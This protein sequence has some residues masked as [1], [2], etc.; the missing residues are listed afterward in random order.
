[1][2]IRKKIVYQKGIDQKIMHKLYCIIMIFLG[3]FNCLPVSYFIHDAQYYLKH[4]ANFS[5]ITDEFDNFDVNSNH[6]C[7]TKI[8][9][10]FSYSITNDK[11]LISKA[12]E[13]KFNRDIFIIA[14][15]E[16]ISEEPVKVFSNRNGKVGLMKVSGEIIIK[17][18]YESILPFSENLAIIKFNKK[19]GA[20]DKNGTIVIPPQ[21]EDMESFENGLARVR[22]NGKWGI[23]NKTGN[24][25]IPIEYIEIGNFSEGLAFA[26][27]DGYLFG[28]IDMSNNFIIPPVFK[29]A[30]AFR[31]GIAPASNLNRE[32]GY[33]NKSGYYIIS[34]KYSS[35]FSF[36]SGLAI[37]YVKRGFGVIDE[38]GKLV[39]PAQFS[40]LTIDE[41]FKIIKATH[42]KDWGN[43]LVFDL[44]NCWVVK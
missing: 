34:P 11:I 43:D 1:M 36:Q 39:F 9:K 15:E 35:A 17:P 41:K 44:H 8:R 37:V 4:D 30:G 31:N 10:L 21:Y 16:N 19:W 7:R 18:L 40:H 2:Q 33:I 42:Y 23:I 14:K 12:N 5:L 38:I 28:Y 6:P 24:N 3:I 20:V 25:V 13:Y 22:L 32:Y 27:K 29:N 26:S